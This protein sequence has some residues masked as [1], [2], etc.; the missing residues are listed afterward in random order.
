MQTIYV[1]LALLCAS[2]AMADGSAFDKLRRELSDAKALSFELG[3]LKDD[4]R[5]P[6]FTHAVATCASAEDRD[7]LYTKRFTGHAE[8]S[9]DKFHPVYLFDDDG[10]VRRLHRVKTHAGLGWNLG[11]RDDHDGLGYFVLREVQSAG[12][13]PLTEFIY[14]WQQHL[15][16]RPTEVCRFTLSP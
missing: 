8:T 2:L 1:G 11:A 5:M 13:A 4:F 16:K 10:K 6:N 9:K 12:V 15:S 7:R 3:A 14:S